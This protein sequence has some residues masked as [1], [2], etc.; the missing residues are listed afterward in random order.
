MKGRRKLVQFVKHNTTFHKSDG[1]KNILL[2]S[3]P[4]SGS[5]WL[6]Q[7]M[8][9]QPGFKL[10][11]EPFNLRQPV[12]LDYLKINEWEELY[13]IQADEKIMRYMHTF[14]EG[15]DNDF[16]FKRERIFA[17]TWHFRTHRIIFKILHACEDR[18]DWFK[19]TFNGEVIFLIRH[20]IPVSVSR[21]K[22]PRLESFLKS[23]YQ[24][25]FTP[26][27]LKYAK[28]LIDKGDIF[29]QAILDWC[30]QNALPLRNRKDDWLV[31]SYEETVLEQEKVIEL[32]VDK[33]NFE[34]PERMYKR[35]HV[36]SGSTHMSDKETRTLL[37]DSNKDKIK[38]KKQWLVEKWKD[39]VTEA[40]E[41]RAF[42]ILEIFDIDFYEIN[43]FLPKDEYLVAPATF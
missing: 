42:E 37:N 9:T 38:E 23:D 28:H 36:A 32:L 26:A 8:G 33:F 21:K 12:V 10:V 29:E 2:F 1:S 35:L 11:R 40:Q 17:D 31:L 41:R 24:R 43:N 7:I 25:H 18:I 5:T 15:N 22:L 27:Q 3:S 6:T 14:M 20:P 16:R 19:D 4:R 39:K 13:S 30:F 34:K